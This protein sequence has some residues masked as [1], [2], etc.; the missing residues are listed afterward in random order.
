MPSPKD[1]ALVLLVLAVLPQ[2]R[3]SSF[4]NGGSGVAHRCT[5]GGG[6][7]CWLPPPTVAVG[8]GAALRTATPLRQGRRA[9]TGVARR[10]GPEQLAPAAT[11]APKCAPA[12]EDIERDL[13]D[14]F[15][16]GVVQLWR[17]DIAPPEAL[18]G[19]A[20]GAGHNVNSSRTHVEPAEI[21]V[22]GTSHISLASAA[23]VE[24]VIRAV[25]PNNVVVELCRSR[26]G[27]MYAEDPA[28]T[29]DAATSDSPRAEADRP[30]PLSI[31]GS[32]PV[33]VPALTQQSSRRADS[34]ARTHTLMRVHTHTHPH[35]HTHTHTHTPQAIWRSLALGGPWALLL[36]VALSKNPALAKTFGRTGA[37][38]RAA[39]R[40]ADELGATVVLGDRPIEITIERAWR[41]LPL[42]GRIM[43]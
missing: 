30:S 31:S 24:R 28:P 9:R 2:H 6:A 12:R 17:R 23:D 27:M 1:A 38:F 19:G 22:V 32:N 16:S 3:C 11:A 25:Q 8:L 36:R 43:C 7:A 18:A 34:H 33:Q 41:A 20:R 40:T 21:Y 13:Q 39:R 42:S 4:S 35:T 5:G 26:A 14:L 15:A 29:P 10:C 37:D